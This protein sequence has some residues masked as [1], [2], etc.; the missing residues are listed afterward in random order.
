MCPEQGWVQVRGCHSPGMAAVG[1]PSLTMGSQLSCGVSANLDIRTMWK[2]SRF[3]SLLSFP[4]HPTHLG[5]LV[6]VPPLP[7]PVTGTAPAQPA[8]LVSLIPLASLGELDPCL[9]LLIILGCISFW[10]VPCLLV[11]CH[12]SQRSGCHPRGGG[13]QRGSWWAETPSMC[14]TS[15][16]NLPV[17]CPQPACS[18]STS[19]PWCICCSCCSCPGSRGPASMGPEVRGSP[20]W[21]SGQGVGSV[22]AA[23]VQV[24]VLLPLRF[25][26]SRAVWLR[27]AASLC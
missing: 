9:G 27:V 10:G 13:M 14:C 26:P 3:C 1:G 21:G 24:P 15:G 25:S 20:G 12:L 5:P 22:W 8:A 18:A 11:G 19:S 7:V 2:C 16:T 23:P 17:P 4:C 6:C